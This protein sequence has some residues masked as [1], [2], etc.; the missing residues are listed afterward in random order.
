MTQGGPIATDPCCLVVAGRHERNRPISPIR[1]VERFDL[2]AKSRSCPMHSDYFS[3][4]SCQ[5][6]GF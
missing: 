6:F 3:Y 5:C 1:V 2:R 4:R